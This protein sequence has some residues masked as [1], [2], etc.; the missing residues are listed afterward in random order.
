MFYYA[1]TADVRSLSASQIAALGVPPEVATAVSDLTL[2]NSAGTCG[3]QTS[4]IGAFN[5]H[6]DGI[7]PLNLEYD[8]KLP[9]TPRVI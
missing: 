9:R 8:P 1:P 6:D 7:Y 4:I 3:A 2:V 5:E